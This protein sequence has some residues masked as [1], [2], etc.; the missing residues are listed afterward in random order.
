M[1]NISAKLDRVLIYLLKEVDVTRLH[2]KQELDYLL[3]CALSCG[4]ALAL[5]FYGQDQ[6]LFISP[7]TFRWLGEDENRGEVFL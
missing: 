7:D 1:S 5:H 3:F 2:L 4:Q 6:P